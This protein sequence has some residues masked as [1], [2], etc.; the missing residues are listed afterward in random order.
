MEAE[1]LE[2][3]QLAVAQPLHGVDGP[4]PERVAG[5]GDVSAEDLREA[6]GDRSQPQTVLDLAVRAAEVARE[7]HPRAVGQEE[8][9][10]RDRGTDARIV[11]DLAVLQRDVE[12]DADEDALAG[13]V[14]VADRELVHGDDG[15]ARRGQAA[16]PAVDG[17]FE[18]TIAMRSA[19][20]QL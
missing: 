13:D 11:R 7:D 16:V 2:E 8:V 14:R 12:I 17:S 5:D 18:A 10:R 9:D 1:V 19:Q 15:P 20:R 6:L 4:H 3:E